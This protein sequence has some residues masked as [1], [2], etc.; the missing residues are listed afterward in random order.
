[1]YVPNC[2]IHTHRYIHIANSIQVTYINPV[3]LANISWRYYIIQCV[4]IAILLAVVYYTMVETKGL[5]L[6]EV[7]IMFDGEEQ[8]MNAAEEAKVNAV[9]DVKHTEMAKDVSLVEEAEERS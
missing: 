4:F 8:F 1:M 7:A 6:E 2:P 5:T 9:S 3:G